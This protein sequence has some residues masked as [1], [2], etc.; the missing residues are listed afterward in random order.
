MATKADT[1]SAVAESSGVTQ[2]DTERVLTAFFDLVKA[3]VKAEEKIAWPGFGTF[4]LS[5]RGP[6][7]GRNPRTGEEIQIGPSRSIKLS[8]AAGAKKELMA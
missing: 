2:T 6:R 4:S 3:Q 7:K 1:V 5:K 8:T